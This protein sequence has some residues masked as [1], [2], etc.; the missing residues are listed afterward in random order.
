MNEEPTMKTCENCRFFRR[1]YVKRSDRFVAVE[2]GHC[3]S[4]EMRFNRHLQYRKIV[5]CALWEMA[6]EKLSEETTV[7]KLLEEIEE[8]L[9]N[10]KYLLTC[11]EK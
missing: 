3:A 2:F 4:G 9:T 5:N 7:K 11:K 10:V 8:K 1:H 6:E